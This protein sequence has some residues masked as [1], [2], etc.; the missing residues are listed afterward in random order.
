[1][2]TTISVR[3]GNPIL[4][5]LN[6][7]EKKW[8]TDRSEVIRRLLADA[9]QGWKLKNA[10]EKIHLHKLSIG[11]AAEECE[12][13]LWEMLDLVRDKN[14]DWTEYSAQDLERDL[15]YLK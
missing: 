4:K 12:I 10:I 2:E 13:P 6:E 5:D 15:K 11:K 1:M 14:T 3:I 8:Q 7:I 9:I